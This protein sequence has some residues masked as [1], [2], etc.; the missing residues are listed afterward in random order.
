MCP[1][2]TEYCNRAK[3]ERCVRG[4]SGRGT[5][6]NN[7]CQCPEGWGGPDCSFRVYV[8]K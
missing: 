5:C 6:V 3:P 8:I 4:C 7:T 2:P 1:D